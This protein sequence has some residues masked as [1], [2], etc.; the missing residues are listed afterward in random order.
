MPDLYKGIAGQIRVAK[1]KA[2]LMPLIPQLNAAV[3]TMANATNPRGWD[4]VSWAKAPHS[5]DDLI[6]FTDFD[7]VRMQV[8]DG[9]SE[10]TIFGDAE[11]NQAF[12]AWHDAVHYDL[13]APFTI[14]GEAAVAFTQVGQLVRRYGADGAVIE[15]SARLLSEVIGQALHEVQF[16]DF[17]ADQVQFSI[18]D[19]PKWIRL[20][21]VLVGAMA[22]ECS[23][24][25]QDCYDGGVKAVAKRL[26]AE[27]FG[28]Y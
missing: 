7:K 6:V 15:W 18:E 5:L 24:V 12:R 4:A 27:A 16:G 25:V 19:T 3:M 11:H 22:E 14:A 8:W 10:V 17:P 21:N 13:Q 20:A 1:C 2:G 9:A 28:A 23:Q 26:A